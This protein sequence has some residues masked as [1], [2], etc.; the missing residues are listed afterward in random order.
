VSLAL[1]LD[2][3]ALD[4]KIC[5]HETRNAFKLMHLFIIALVE[6]NQDLQ[7]RVPLIKTL[8]FPG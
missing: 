4:A 7:H 3:L 5:L 6:Y 8:P 2:A 1:A